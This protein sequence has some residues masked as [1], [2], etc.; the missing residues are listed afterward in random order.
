MAVAERSRVLDPVREAGVVMGMALQTT[1]AQA[2][3][4]AQACGCRGC[5]AAA[6][7]TV[8]WAERLL[9]APEYDD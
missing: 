6:I 3:H 1:V 9:G 7:E 4:R 8:T 5:R 2:I